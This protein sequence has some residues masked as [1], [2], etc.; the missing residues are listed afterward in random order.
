M[1]LPKTEH[2]LF[3][4]TVP[5]TQ[6]KFNFRRFL[7]KEEKILLIAKQSDEKIDKL[8]AMEQVIVNCAMD[9]GFEVDKLTTFD[10]D[11]VFLKLRAASVDNMVEIQYFDEEDEKDHLVKIN[12]DKI[13]I[14]MPKDIK[15]TVALSSDISLKLKYPTMKQM[16]DIAEKVESDLVENVDKKDHVPIEM[17][18]LL[19]EQCIDKIYDSETVYDDYTSEELYEW[20]DQLEATA[21]NDI[22]AF[23]NSIPDLQYKT[24][25]KNSKGT[26]REVE[27]KGIEDF[28]TL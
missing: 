3:I 14:E 23:L 28:F 17:A 12:L 19:I 7:T 15:T 9:P 22:K 8:R 18:D 6:K 11:Y 4:I 16:L 24:S 10:F 26:V 25:Y 1:P 5:S 21:Y 13:E 20:L 2:P 27:L